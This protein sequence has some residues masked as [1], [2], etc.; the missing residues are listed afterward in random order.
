MNFLKAKWQNLVMANYAVPPSL[1]E[2]Y[3]PPG[4]ELDFHEGKTY[5]SLVGFMF[6]QTRLFG[7][8]IPGL[9]NFEEINLR[10]YVIRKEKEEIRRGVVFIGETV[11]SAI[12]AWVA[13][14]LY[15]EHYS[16]I[17]TRHT[18]LSDETTLSVEYK[19][20]MPTGWNHL[21]VLAL[22]VSHIM[23]KGSTEEFI[24]EHYYGYTSRVNRQSQEYKVE[25]E[26]WQIHPVTSCSIDCDFSNCYGPAFAFL[27]FAEPDSIF[28]SAGS[29]VSVKWKRR[30]LG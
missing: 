4:T 9:G 27:S 19:W 16:A 29:K 15:S 17:P 7:I 22:S 13:N 12:V 2:P 28:L 20:K 11:P 6:L 14:K 24:F 10:F 18:W 25:H 30:N 21:R 5:V 1:L 8:P 23:E 3:L 26:R